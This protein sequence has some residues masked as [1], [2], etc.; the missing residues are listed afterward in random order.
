MGQIS[1]A[2]YNKALSDQ[3]I[4]IDD[5][6]AVGGGW[7]D[8]GNYNAAPAPAP[9]DPNRAYY[10]QQEQ[11]LN[12][13]LDLLGRQKSVGYGNIDNSYNTARNRLG[14]QKARA[15]RDYNTGIGDTEQ[16]FSSAR[17]TVAS[18]VR[19][20]QNALQRLLGIAGSGNSSAAFDAVPLATAREGSQ[21][22]APV[23]STYAQNRRNLDTGWE[24]TLGSYNDGLQDLASQRQAQRTAIDQNILQTK[25]D[26]LNK[27]SGLDMQRGEAPDAGFASQMEQLLS[28]MAGLG[29]TPGVKINKNIAF[30]SKPLSAY[31]LGPQ[32]APTQQTPESEGVDPYLLPILAREEDQ[33]ANLG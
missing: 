22:L 3:A 16:G 28:R 27:L 11:I 30:S 12:Q 1:A 32:K 4:V 6:P 25:M 9:V 29:A 7:T 5:V 26:I 19:A 33:L 21:Q 17:N 8:Y 18:N 15:F 23:Q 20:R 10:D 24:D 14:D 31:S 2:D 13:Q